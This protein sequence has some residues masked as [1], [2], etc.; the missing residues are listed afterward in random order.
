MQAKEGFRKMVGLSKERPA[1]H[2]RLTSLLDNTTRL[3]GPRISCHGTPRDGAR[4][5][6]PHVESHSIAVDQVQII[7]L[8]LLRLPSS[9]ARGDLGL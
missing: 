4:P 5:T 3:V 6:P 7:T 8:S 9:V 2:K 1:W